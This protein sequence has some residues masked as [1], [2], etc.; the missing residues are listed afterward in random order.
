MADK[1]LSDIGRRELDF[2]GSLVSEALPEWFREDNP[3]LITLLEK[4]HE[5]LDSDGNFGQRLKTIPT[6]R[7]IV[8]TDA[9]NLTFIEDELLL[10]QNYLKGTLDARTSA[11]LSNNFYRSKGTKFGIQRFFNMFFGETPDIIYGKDLTFQVGLDEIGPG[12]EKR[13]TDDKIFQ[14]WGIL[15]KL[16]RTSNEWLELYKLFAHPA[17]M[18]V[19]SEVAIESKNADISFDFMDSQG[20]EPIANPQFVGVATGIPLG[21]Q[22]LSGI[23]GKSRI[24]YNT[25]PANPFQTGW[26]ADSDGITYEG[27]Y[28]IDFGRI[29]TEHFADSAG[30]PSV[31]TPVD[32]RQPFINIVDRG[33]VT[34]STTST[35]NLGTVDATTDSS[36]D[37]GSFSVNQFATLGYLDNTYTSLV[38]AV[39]MSSPTMD[40]D[41]AAF[42][43]V[44]RFSNVQ[45]T[46][47]EDE[48]K[49][50]LDSNR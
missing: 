24:P 35:I 48:F 25:D 27:S 45:R 22:D 29:S 46:M 42:N 39:R 7:D 37:F 50:Y 44:M 32:L 12:T 20:R 40:E 17:G 4:Y 3:K 19:G 34:A 10:G 26:P 30:A 31:T 6:V 41:S 21:R 2:T 36:E 23:I 1:T 18:F 38:D 9:E 43:G 33:L 16:G 13:I 5:N 49:Y 47:D 8:Q 15:L 28:R 14:F 11:S